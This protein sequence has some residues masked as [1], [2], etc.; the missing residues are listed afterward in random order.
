M[1][2]TP[3]SSRSQRFLP[4]SKCVPEKSQRPPN[5]LTKKMET[6][7]TAGKK[8]QGDFLFFRRR[9]TFFISDIALVESRATSLPA[10]ATWNC[11][12]PNEHEDQMNTIYTHQYTH[13]YRERERCIEEGRP[14][15]QGETVIPFVVYRVRKNRFFAESKRAHIYI[16]MYLR[17]YTHVTTPSDRSARSCIYRARVARNQP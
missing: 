11:W 1:L 16:R 17:C 8:E 10:A 5:R 7:G 15:G 13:V 12:R 3:P 9:T 14:W 4:I 2:C 6:M